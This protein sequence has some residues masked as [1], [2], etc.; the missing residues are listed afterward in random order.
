MTISGKTSVYGIIGDPISHSLSPVFW[1]AA[2]SALSMD[3]VYVPFRVDPSRLKQAF[4][5]L[6]AANVLAINV[7]KPFKEGVCGFVS[8]LIPP[9]EALQAVNTIQF[10][11]KGKTRGFNTDAHAF[12]SLFR[13]LKTVSRVILLGA[14]GAAKSLLWGL[15]QSGVDV[16]YWTNRT[17]SRLNYSPLPTR[18]KIEMVKWGDVEMLQA[19]EK[20]SVII[21]ATTLGWSADDRLQPLEKALNK[22][23]TYIDLN[24]GEKS[25]LISIAKKSG[26]HVIDGF[27]FLI[28]QGMEAFHRLTGR[29]APE[30]VIRE[31]LAQYRAGIH[32]EEPSS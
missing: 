29:P 13:E 22:E 19:M 23:K 31:S 11:E 17:L 8:E 21:N 1:N 3:A 14:G 9:A 12:L 20:S 24:Y 2:F 25:Q 5:G 4:D 32:K 27:E 6:S 16:V 10:L 30:Q 28:R 18:T 26:A 15:C 7:T